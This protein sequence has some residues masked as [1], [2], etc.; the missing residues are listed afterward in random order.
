MKKLE[1]NGER[2]LNYTLLL[3]IICTAYVLLRIVLNARIYNKYL[4]LSQEG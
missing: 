3:D 4:V 2:D 1:K